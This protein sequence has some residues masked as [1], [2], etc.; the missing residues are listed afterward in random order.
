MIV[1]LLVQNDG[2]YAFQRAWLNMFSKYVQRIHA[3]DFDAL[4]SEPETMIGDVTGSGTWRRR[5]DVRSTRGF[6]STFAFVR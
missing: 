2:S 3:L 1:R 5:R 4:F 6:G